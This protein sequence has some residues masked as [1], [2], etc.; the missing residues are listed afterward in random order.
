MKIN[1]KIWFKILTA[2][3]TAGMLMS[4]IQMIAFANETR[5]ITYADGSKIIYT[6]SNGNVSSIDYY[7]AE[8]YETPLYNYQYSYNGNKINSVICNV[9]NSVSDETEKFKIVDEDNF[10]KFS[11]YIVKNGA[12]TE[13][14]LYESNSSIFSQ[15]ESF[16]SCF[17]NIENKKIDTA[18]TLLRSN[19]VRDSMSFSIGKDFLGYNQI[20]YSVTSLIEKDGIGRIKSNRIDSNFANQLYP[21]NIGDFNHN[22]EYVYLDNGTDRSL[23]SEYTISGDMMENSALPETFTSTALKYNGQGMPQFKYYKLNEDNGT[24]YYLGNFYGYDSQNRLVIETDSINN[25]YIEYFYDE[26]NNL[27]EKRIFGETAK[28]SLANKPDFDIEQLL[29]MEESDF[30]KFDFSVFNNERFL[31]EDNQYYVYNYCFDPMFKDRM[32]EYTEKEC[33]KNGD[34]IESTTKVN[35][36][37]SYDACGN[38]LNYVGYTYE[39]LI[40]ANLKWCGNLL[41]EFDVLDENRK[42]IRIFTYEYDHNGN[43]VAK[44]KYIRNNNDTFDLHSAQNFIWNNGILQCVIFKGNIL[45]FLKNDNDYNQDFITYSKIIYD[46]NHSPIAYITPVGA[47]YQ[48][49]KDFKGNIIGLQSTTDDH[50]TNNEDSSVFVEMRYDSYGL[51]DFYYPPKV[52]S[53]KYNSY[54]LTALFNPCTY[55]D[56]LY[57]YESG[58]YYAQNEY[59]SPLWGKNIQTT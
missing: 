43:R 58:M 41:T 35:E 51:I 45:N 38:P 50:R 21:D 37:I 22:M 2:V 30:N 47:M 1:R 23:V 48:Y 59:Y 28:I 27:Y 9:S 29:I 57:D 46:A 16:Y 18:V 20:D 56:Y 3:L 54:M 36:K 12:E 40:R 25:K 49:I 5:V 24:F 4:N 11:E 26:N 34:N 10:Y 8:D 13:R 53:D 17:G 14:L 55:K 7:S 44:K 6:Y 31:I 42:V 19:K 15:T 32:V 33:V 52:S 39:G